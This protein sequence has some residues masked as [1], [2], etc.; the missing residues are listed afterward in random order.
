MPVSSTRVV[1]A[2]KA[3]IALDGQPSGA[4]RQED[5]AV[6]DNADISKQL[7]VNMTASTTGKTVTL[8]AGANAADIILTLPTTSGTLST[9]S[10]SGDV[11]GPASATASALAVYDGTTGKLLKSSTVTFDTG[12]GTVYHGAGAVHAAGFLSGASGVY[13]D[14][15]RKSVASDGT[16]AINTSTRQLTASDESVNVTW[17]TPNEVSVAGKFTAG[18][19]VNAASGSGYKIRNAAN[20]VDLQA[21]DSLAAN[22]GRGIQLGT[23]ACGILLDQSIASPAASLLVLEVNDGAGAY[24][25]I[26]AIAS[27]VEVFGASDNNASTGPGSIKLYNAAGDGNVILRGPSSV[28]SVATVYQ[29]PDDGTNGQV[30]STN[31]SGALSWV[32]SMQ[33]SAPLTGVTVDILDPTTNL[34]VNPAGTIAALTLTLPPASDGKKFTVSSSEIITALTLT[35]DGSDTI[36]NNVTAMTA[37]Q[38]FTFIARSGVWYRG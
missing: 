33:Y 34:I 29:L 4:T 20:T 27:V 17:A 10:A 14:T 9:S 1:T 31:G 6:C 24:G 23:A 8:T 5:F 37:G 38:A 32:N 30:L 26:M 18:T 28:G 15:I 12:D 21:I 25:T 19:S 35:P 7:R 3:L 22:N 11:V 13:T 36:K 2:Q 16:L